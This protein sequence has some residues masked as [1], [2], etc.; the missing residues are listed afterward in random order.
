VSKQHAD[1]PSDAHW[2]STKERRGA[3][4]REIC[5]S[6]EVIK[7]TSFRSA[8]L[9]SISNSSRMNGVADAA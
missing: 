6:S 8:K 5:A 1:I 2:S 7:K 3:I 9:V 4:K